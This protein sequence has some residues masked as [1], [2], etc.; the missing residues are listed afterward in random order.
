MR[1]LNLVVSATVAIGAAIFAA[2]TLAAGAKPAV[3][4]DTIVFAIGRDIA[5][6]DAQVDNTGNSD[7]YAW[8]MYDNLYT[9]DKTGALV[10]QVATGVT[11]A[12]GG[13]EYRFA[14]R[15]DVHGFFA[16]SRIFSI[17]DCISHHR[18]S[19]R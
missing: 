16:R 5:M 3:D 13:L 6:L 10:P 18:R 17:P 19:M 9:F 1:S 11:I 2:P 12:P 14:L 7:R 15:K 4:E 8:Q